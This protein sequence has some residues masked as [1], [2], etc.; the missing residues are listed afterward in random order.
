MTMTAGG[1]EM[2]RALAIQARSQTKK[3]DADLQTCG[4]ELQAM[5]HLFVCERRPHRLTKTHSA[6]IQCDGEDAA[7]IAT[8]TWR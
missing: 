4:S 3:S 6:T 2:A 7:V 1:I 8:I 5:G